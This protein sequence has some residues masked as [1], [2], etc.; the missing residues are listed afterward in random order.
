MAR[1]RFYIYII[2]FFI[3][4]MNQPN[5]FESFDSNFNFYSI[6][7]VFF[8]IILFFQSSVKESSWI[9][10]ETFFLLGFVIVHFQVPFLAC[11]G[12]EP[13]KPKLVWVNK[14]VV[15]YATWLSNL[16]IMAWIIGN[17]LQSLFKGFFE[18][19]KQKSTGTE[20]GLFEFNISYL[21]NF[22]YVFFILFLA[23]VGKEFLNGNYD[24]G[25]NWGAGAIY[26]YLVLR[27]V[28]YLK[29][30]Y[31]FKLEYTSETT[32][33]SV[34]QNNFKFLFFVFIYLLLFLNAGDRGPIIE[35]FIVSSISY[36][37]FVDKLKLKYI[38]IGALFFSFFLTI[39]KAGRSRDVSDRE[40]NILVQG[41]A[42][43]SE[44][45]NIFN[46]TDELASTVRILYLGLDKVPYNHPYLSGITFLHETISVVPF[47]MSF[48]LQYFPI[49]ETYFS[50]SRFFTIL[51]QGKN[52]S[53]GDGSEILADI[54]VNFGQVG[55]IVLM[56]LFG[57]L[58]AF[59]KNKAIHLNHDTWIIVYIFLVVGALYMNRSS[60]LDPLKTIF[61]ALFLNRFLIRKIYAK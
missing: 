26:V 18:A 33:L 42:N 14:Q 54:Y 28:L 10:F 39:I 61:Y 52:Y 44:N 4:L 47:G 46:P 27:V 9:S 34:I 50:T 23:L 22:F 29:I 24:G 57:F 11:F 56:F 58:V 7:L 19:R 59:I 8:N 5:A 2:T 30:V 38:L 17:S 31:F 55:T 48:Y 49:P 60:L 20:K 1:F 13:G 37:L 40:Q 3:L 32:F 53:S 43:A 15:N 35:F 41:Y 25:A 51:R 36:T 21:N 6:V 45:E 16:S 12:I